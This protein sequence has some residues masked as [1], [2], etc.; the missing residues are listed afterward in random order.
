MS[1]IPQPHFDLP[2]LLSTLFNPHVADTS[3]NDICTATFE[4]IVV[5]EMQAKNLY[6]ATMEQADSTLWMEQRKGRIT[7][8]KAHSVLRC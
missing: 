4:T 5:T 7:A 6:E 1:S 8:S 3:L 2:L